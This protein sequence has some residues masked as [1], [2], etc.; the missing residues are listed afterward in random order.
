MAG[1]GSMQAPQVAVEAGMVDRQVQF[2]TSLQLSLQLSGDC[3]LFCVPDWACWR[4][5]LRARA[6]P[7]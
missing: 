6:G 2:L 7:Q 4:A 3:R 5:L 1:T